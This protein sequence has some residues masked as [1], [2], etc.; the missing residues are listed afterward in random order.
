MSDGFQPLG[1]RVAATM[2]VKRYGDGNGACLSSAPPHQPPKAT[3]L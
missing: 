1:A 3:N 2:A